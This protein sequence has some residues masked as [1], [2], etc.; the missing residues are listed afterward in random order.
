MRAWFLRR[1]VRAG[2]PVDKNEIGFWDW[3]L[4]A[5]I[6]DVEHGRKNFDDV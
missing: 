2:Y 4:I 5:T 3:W 6:E 1:L